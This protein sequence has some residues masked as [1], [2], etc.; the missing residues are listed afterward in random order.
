MT[1]KRKPRGTLARLDVLEDTAATRREAVEAAKDAIWG[2]VFDGMT[3]ED[4]QAVIA[5]CDCQEENGEQWAEMERLS[6]GMTDPGPTDPVGKAAWAWQDAHINT[7]EGQPWP[8]PAD[9]EAFAAYFDGE[10][11]KADEAGACLPL[12]PL[13]Q[14]DA[15]WAAAWWRMVAAFLREVGRD[16]RGNA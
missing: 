13:L 4:R 15:R 8:V 7:P 9:P 14:V 10:A 12:A 16:Q 1:A 11:A 6:G 3:R 2:R 5:L